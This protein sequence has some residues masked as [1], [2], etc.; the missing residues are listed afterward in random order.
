MASGVV[1]GGILLAGDQLLGVEELAVGAQA[2]LVDD[3]WFEIDEDG[4]R[5]VLAG[6]ALREEGVEGVVADADGL[7]GRHLA[8]GLDAMLKAGIRQGYRDEISLT[9]TLN[10]I[11][12]LGRL[13]TGCKFFTCHSLFDLFWVKK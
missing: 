5:D 1:V 3:G 7:V 11:P 2:D 10:I 12:I 9:H 4:S 8:V 6:S 13:K